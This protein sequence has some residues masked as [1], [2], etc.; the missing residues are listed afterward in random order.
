M[1]NNGFT[2]LEMLLVLCVL[3]VFLS[4][5]PL[6]NRHRG[7]LKWESEKIK[8]ILIAEQWKAQQD[9]EIREIAIQNNT[10]TTQAT[11]YI[12]N[13]SITCEPKDVVFNENGNV[14]LA[15]T[16]TCFSADRKKEVV[17]TLGKASIYV[18]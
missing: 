3:S 15:D 11:T 16:I 2:L 17:I 13:P 8:D 5:V 12:L 14:T 7:L 9:K 10:V 1:N 18:R 4:I 6:A